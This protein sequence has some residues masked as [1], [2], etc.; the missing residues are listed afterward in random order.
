MEVALGIATLTAAVIAITAAAQKF[1][2]PA[3]L[4]LMVVGIAASFVPQIPQVHLTSELVLLGL[5][6]PL[7]YA[8]AIRSSVVDFRAQAWAIGLLSVGLVVI[9]ALGIGVV[10][11]LLLPV[12]F[13][14]GVAIGAV[15]APPDAVAATS[16][17][18]RVGL[19][20]RVITILEGESLFNDAT[21]IT[22]LRVAIL[23]MT[24]GI[25]VFRIGLSFLIAAGGGVAIGLAV[26]FLAVRIR[27][28]ITS[29]RLDNAL[30][31]LLPFAAYL[32]AEEV[33]ISGMHAS[34]VIAVVTAGLIIGHKAPVV[35]T[36][37]S[38]LSE[39]MNWTTIQF[40]LEN[41]VFLLIGLQARWI[42]ADLAT[43]DIG[44]GTIIALFAA[45]FGGVIV[46]RLLMT[47]L[48]RLVL[49]HGGGSRSW[50]STAIIGWAGMRGV[51]TLA[52]AFVLPQQTPFRPLLVFLAMAVTAGSLLLQ[53][54]TLPALARRLGLRGPDARED[55][56]QAASVLQSS[57]RAAL[58]K[59]EEIRRPTDAETTIDQLRERI[60]RRTNEM[61]EHLGTESDVETPAEE[62][63]RL[64]LQT[65][66]AERE[67]VLQIRAMGQIDHEV[68]D[69]VLYTLDVEESMLTVLEDQTGEVSEAEPLITRASLEGDCQHLRDAPHVVKPDGPG[70]CRDC[71]REG[72]RWVHLRLCL[73]CGNVGCCDSSIGKHASR[74]FR[75]TG[76]PVMR[77]FEQGE[78]WRWCFIDEALG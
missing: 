30:S 32:P 27:K 41:A 20:R 77:S 11:H 6:P 49:V 45:V 8:A 52:A 35:Q 57:S 39:R 18:R 31:L 65:I 5:L 76:H 37:R 78:K 70:G 28:M 58:E 13:S 40:L 44:V 59:L 23:A 63:R 54:L 61:W 26:A 10:V 33:D 66:E 74:H 12:P 2:L 69:D 43:V 24:T 46:I 67:E 21:A 4:V 68:I 17:A 34:G 29:A 7:L 1:N 19:P 48:S 3:P 71:E 9:T 38:R 73:T 56:L 14:V 16:V 36:A 51:V 42:V 75:D 62:Y 15:V 22:C 53:G 72:L 25:G 60:S 50:A 47:V 64:R 55:A